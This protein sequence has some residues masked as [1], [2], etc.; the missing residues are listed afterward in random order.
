MRNGGTDLN[1]DTKA[2]GIIVKSIG[3]LYGVRP[4]PYCDDDS[5][6]LCRA[7][8]VFR[9]ESISPL[10]GDT[11][12]FERDTG[13]GI[14]R[15]RETKSADHVI[16]EIL[17]R[18]NALIRPPL[19]NLTHIFVVIPATHPEPDL[20]TADKLISIAEYNGIEPVI[21]INKCDLDGDAARRIAGIYSPHFATHLVSKNDADSISALRDFIGMLKNDD[22]STVISAFAGVSGAGKSTIMSLLFPSLSFKSGELSAKIA[23]GKNTTR[24]SELYAFGTGNSVCFIADTPGFSLI[25]FTRFNFYP[26][27]ELPFLFREFGDYLPN[28]RYTSCT[29]TSEDNCGVIIALRS[30][31][32]AESRHESYKVIYADLKKKPDWKRIKELESGN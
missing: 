2:K 14:K 5:V 3:G 12:T 10:V 25:D 11:V 13:D 21:I 31:L 1:P 23:R 19:A 4:V 15:E 17:P 29:H 16:T 32:I 28:C 22:G 8:G 18:R 9:H 6:F 27:A 26:S 20:L 24:H 30:G 7:R